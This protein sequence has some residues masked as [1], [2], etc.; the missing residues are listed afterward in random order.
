M[1]LI[2]GELS[3]NND[4][5]YV[6]TMF[7]SM[8]QRNHDIRQKV[9]RGL[10]LSTGRTKSRGIT[11]CDGTEKNMG[12]VIVMCAISLKINMYIVWEKQIASAQQ[13]HNALKNL[14]IHD[15]SI[16]S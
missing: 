10:I 14:F 3:L 9:S 4:K 16:L 8:L 11:I 12:F 5:Y 6:Q 13:I 15:V 7:V 1:H 2:D